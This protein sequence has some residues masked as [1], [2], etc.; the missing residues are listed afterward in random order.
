MSELKIQIE[1]TLLQ[2]NVFPGWIEEDKWLK[3]FSKKVEV[4]SFVCLTFSHKPKSLKT[5]T[6]GEYVK[7]VKG[8]EEPSTI[9]TSNKNLILGEF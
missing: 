7:I 4:I 8:G 5:K 3:T 2:M 6:A 1:K 9:G